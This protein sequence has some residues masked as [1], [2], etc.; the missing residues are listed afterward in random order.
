MNCN[1]T[2]GGGTCIFEGDR[3][4]D[5]RGTCQGQQVICPHDGCDVTCGLGS[6]CP[7]Q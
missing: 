7:R 1:A 5:C 2:T 4:T 3:N 6:F